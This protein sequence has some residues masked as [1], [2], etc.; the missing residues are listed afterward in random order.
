M[1]VRFSEMKLK[2]YVVF[3]TNRAD[4]IQFAI[5]R[6]RNTVTVSFEDNDTRIKADI[7]T[8]INF[9]LQKWETVEEQWHWNKRMN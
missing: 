9:I 1:G 7:S 6:L 3:I 2:T 4:C 5:P 8:E